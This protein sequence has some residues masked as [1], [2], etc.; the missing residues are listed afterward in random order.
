M[1]VE[2][3]KFSS[4]IENF[5]ILIEFFIERRRERIGLYQVVHQNRASP[6][7]SDFRRRLRYR[8]EFRSGNR[9]SP[10]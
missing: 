4:G 7:A 2:I 5:K 9:S 3:E 6:F 1:S 8:R 10:F